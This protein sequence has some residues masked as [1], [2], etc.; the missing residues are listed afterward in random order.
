[1]AASEEGPHYSAHFESLR[2]PQERY[3]LDE[4]VYTDRSGGLLRVVHDMEQLK[5]RSPEEWRRTFEQRVL[6]NEWPYGS[7]VWGKKEW[8][9]TA[10][11]ARGP[12]DQALRQFT[13]RLFQG[14]RH[15]R[16]DIGGQ[17]DDRTRQVDPRRRLCIE[18]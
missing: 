7:G 6:R 10:D 17:G 11:R 2:D 9:L 12:V 8:V 3:A 13:H 16:A 4:I 1:M 18:L 15:D 5:R 14:S